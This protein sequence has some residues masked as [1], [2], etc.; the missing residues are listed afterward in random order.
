[1]AVTTE[2]PGGGGEPRISPKIAAIFGLIGPGGEI[3]EAAKAQQEAMS[4][5][6]TAYKRVEKELH[7]NRQAVAMIRKLD[8]MSKD[9]RDDFIRTLEPMLVERGYTLDAIDPED[10]V[11]DTTQAPT[12]QPQGTPPG[13]DGED[14]D[15]QEDDSA[16]GSLPAVTAPMPMADALAASRARLAG[17]GG[18]PGAAGG[19]D[20]G[21]RKLRKLIGAL[22]TGQT[23]T[24]AAMYAGMSSAEATPHAEA[25]KRGEYAAIVPVTPGA[26]SGKGGRPQLGIVTGGQG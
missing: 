16:S 2:E 11:G 10:L 14:A 9:K 15:D 25:E 7:G 22:R 20:L 8:N 12:G 26:R 21:D 5:L 17:G 6:G 1:M 4:K 19:V 3:T 23:L 24:D 13:D 18:E